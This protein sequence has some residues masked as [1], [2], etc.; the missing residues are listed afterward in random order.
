MTSTA[1][2]MA[3]SRIHVP[4]RRVT[5]V[6]TVA[7]EARVADPSL[8]AIVIP[9]GGRSQVG[10]IAGRFTVCLARTV[11]R[12]LVGDVLEVAGR[13]VASADGV[14]VTRGADGAGVE[15]EADVTGGGE[16]TDGG[17]EDEDV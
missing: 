16:T 15:W 7:G 8:Y 3:L 14:V 10:P 4:S 1:S 17:G 6:T 11:G 12:A 2:A 9:V 13:T 5:V